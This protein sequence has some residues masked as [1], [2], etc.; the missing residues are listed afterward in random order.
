[1]LMSMG[2][3]SNGSVLNSHVDRVSTHAVSVI[4]NVDQDVDEAW[5]LEIYSH[6]GSA[7]NVTIQ[8]GDMLLYESASCIHGRPTPLNGRAFVNVFCHTRPK[9]NW[10]KD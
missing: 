8:Q 6:D 9:E 4:I 3:G 10:V 7:H 1:M 5:P 2:R